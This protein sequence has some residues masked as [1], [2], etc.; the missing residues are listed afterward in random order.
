VEKEN[1]RPI[2]D[3]RL[4]IGLVSLGQIK[5]VTTNKWGRFEV[6]LPAGEYVIIPS[7]QGYQ[8]G[9]ESISIQLSERERKVEFTGTQVP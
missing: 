2:A 6:D 9:P 3:V 8:F 1:G 7:K 4:S 5:E